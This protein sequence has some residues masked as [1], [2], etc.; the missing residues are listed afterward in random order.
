MDEEGQEIPQ[1]LK[2]LAGWR[3][4]RTRLGMY[5]MLPPQAEAGDA[6]VVLDGVAVPVLL[7]RVHG[8][9]GGGQRPESLSRRERGEEKE[10]FELVGDAYVHS[11]MGWT[12]GGG[13]GY[14]FGAN[15]G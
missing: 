1:E 11:F 12:G 15:E 10:L 9:G 4:R 2:G 5:C 3:S 8:S 13:R 7:R 6:V 14:G